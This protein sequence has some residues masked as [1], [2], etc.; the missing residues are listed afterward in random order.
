[1]KNLVHFY[2]DFDEF[3]D[4]YVSGKQKINKNKPNWK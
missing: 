2:E 1:M 4:D 3:E